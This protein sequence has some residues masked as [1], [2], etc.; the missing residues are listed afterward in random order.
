MPMS[1]KM[2]LSAH[3]AQ[4]GEMMFWLASA[5]PADEA[6]VV[7]AKRSGSYADQHEPDAAARKAERDRRADE[8][9]H[10]AGR[11]ER[12]LLL[13]LDRRSDSANA[14][15]RRGGSWRRP[16]RSRS[17]VLRS[18]PV[19]APGGRRTGR[20]TRRRV[21]AGRRNRR[22][23]NRGRRAPAPANWDGGS[24]SADGRRS[25]TI[26]R[27]DQRR[28]RLGDEGAGGNLVPGDLLKT[29]PIIT[30]TESDFTSGLAAG[31]FAVS[32]SRLVVSW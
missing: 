29:L 28:G 11:G 2:M 5:S 6:D 18:A 12:E 25:A 15:R 9:E 10:D 20:C 8:H 31:F 1:A 23:R 13:D 24:A 30:V 26:P 3:I 19:A 17:S 14:A 27:R 32:G 7:D 22:R 21:R 4:N 16:S